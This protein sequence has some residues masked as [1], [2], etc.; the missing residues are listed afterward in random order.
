MGSINRIALIAGCIL[1]VW[2]FV[3]TLLRESRA[4]GG[5]RTQVRF[6]LDNLRMIGVYVETY[7]R[8]HGSNTPP[9]LVSLV[10]YVRDRRP[11]FTCF[12]VQNQAR[13][14]RLGDMKDISAD[15]SNTLESLTYVY[16]VDYARSV[17][18]NTVRAFC[19]VLHPKGHILYADGTIKEVGQ[20]EF[21]QTLQSVPDGHFVMPKGKI[22][23]VLPEEL[24]RK[25]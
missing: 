7:K 8:D 17:S 20:S 2:L 11:V 15:R 3:A 6:C 16:V 24:K 19:P 13:G 10:P 5:R 9:D 25:P 4:T 14:M 1:L 23:V 12:V 22:E 18:G 21:Y